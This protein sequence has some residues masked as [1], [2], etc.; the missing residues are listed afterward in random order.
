MRF[1]WLQLTRYSN[2]AGLQITKSKDYCLNLG[3]MG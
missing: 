3:A 1:A 2:S